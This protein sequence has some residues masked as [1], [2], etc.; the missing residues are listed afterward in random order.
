MGNLAVRLERYLEF[1]T[2]KQSK[3]VQESQ[4]FILSQLSQQLMTELRFELMVRSITVHPFFDNVQKV[5]DVAMHRICDLALMRMSFA[6]EDPVFFRSEASEVMYFVAC[7][8]LEYDLQNTR[9]TKVLHG[10]SWQ[11]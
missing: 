7:G 5:S 6:T 8:K 2:E 3:V 11:P 4:I 10:G 1:Q 9:E